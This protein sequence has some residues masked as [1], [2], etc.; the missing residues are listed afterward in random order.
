MVVFHLLAS[1]VFIIDAAQKYIAGIL[2]LLIG[3]G[4]MVV[5][6]L[7]ASLVF[8][9]DELYLVIYCSDSNKLYSEHHTRGLA[10]HKQKVLCPAGS[11]TPTRDAERSVQP[12]LPRRRAVHHGGF[13]HPRRPRLHHNTNDHE[14]EEDP[15]DTDAD[16]EAEEPGSQ[17]IS[18][19]IIAV[20]QSPYCG[21]IW[22]L[23]PGGSSITEDD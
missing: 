13:P 18:A 2:L 11:K 9:I 17:I 8:I 4:V 16:K 15:S 20:N 22:I 6:L 14:E 23:F 5:F 1:L 21:F 7:L 12:C 19:G 3:V 10:S